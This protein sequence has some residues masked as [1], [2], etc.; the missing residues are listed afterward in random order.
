MIDIFSKFGESLDVHELRIA[1]R[2]VYL[3]ITVLVLK[4]FNQK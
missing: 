3:A 2:S 1:A 4:F